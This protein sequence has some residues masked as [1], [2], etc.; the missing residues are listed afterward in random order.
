MKKI[1]LF[2][3][4]LFILTTVFAVNAPFSNTP[5][6]TQVYH[7]ASSNQ[8]VIQSI[9]SQSGISTAQLTTHV[10]SDVQPDMPVLAQAASAP[11]TISPAAVIN[12]AGIDTDTS[13]QGQVS[14]LAESTLAYEQQ[15][16]QRI[17]NLDG[18]NQVI[19]SELQTL[20]QNV[21]QLQQ[22]INVL[23]T[24]RISSLNGFFHVMN[25]KDLVI[26]VSFGAASILLLGFG[27][28]MGRLMHRSSHVDVVNNNNLNR[29]ARDLLTDDAKSEFDF[30]ATREAIPAKL[31]LAR[32]YMVMKDYEQAGA[33]LKTVLEKGDEE[34]RMVAEALLTKIRNTTVI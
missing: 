16:D 20:N 2:L 19:G 26:F 24:R 3:T 11:D 7:A 33:V 27:I 34:Q 5:A 29:S 13:A 32:S 4:T 10:S 22:K 17:Q 30:M 12:S 6:P 18:S 31:D 9:P 23:Q 25:E 15:T 21:A 14:Q 1:I 8:S 28:W